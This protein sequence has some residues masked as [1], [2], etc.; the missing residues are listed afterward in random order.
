MVVSLINP[1]VNY[2]ELTKVN[3]EDKNKELDLYELELL[4]EKVIISIGSIQN[5]F[6]KHNI[7]YFPIYLI[8]K[9]NKGSQIGV[10][11][12]K[13]TNTLDCFDDKG[14]LLIESVGD[15]LLYSFINPEY[16]KELK[17]ILDNM[18]EK[19]DKIEEIEELPEKKE[20]I[21]PKNRIDIFDFIP[22]LFKKVILLKEE[23]HKT[24]KKIRR[25]YYENST[26]SWIQK[27]MK[28]PNYF[29]L[30][31]DLNKDCLFS[32]IKEVFQSIGQQTTIQKIRNKLGEK[33][34]DSLF[35]EYRDIYNTYER[36]I[37]QEKEKI[38][39]VKIEYDKIQQRLKQGVLN[40]EERIKLI[41]R[42]K[43]LYE[44]N[45]ILKQKKKVLKEI[46]EDFLF[47]KDVHS[48]TD[49]RKKVKSCNFW[50]EEWS[51]PMLE[52]LL[53]IKFIILNYNYYKENDIQNV[54][55]CNRAVEDVENNIDGF[56]PEYYILLEK[57]GKHYKIIGYKHK[58]LF[59]Y[60]ELPFDLKLMIQDKCIEK[61]ENSFRFIP[62]F[63]LISSTPQVVE[64]KGTIF[65]G[66][67]LYDKEI[68]F[69]FYENSGDIYL[70]GKGPNE[71]IP[72]RFL[73]EFASLAKEKQWRKK[74]SNFWNQTFMLDGKNWASVVH[75]IEGSKFKNSHRDFYDSFS[76]DSGSDLSKDAK[77]AWY[78]SHSK[79]GLYKGERLRDE[80]IKPDSDFNEEKRQKLLFLAQMAKFTQN[81]ELKQILLNTKNAMLLHQRKKQEPELYNSLML[82]REKIQ[83]NNI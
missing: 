58:V 83:N 21:I 60:Q 77:K 16:L 64:K 68:I 8:K 53:N 69:S 48:T 51:L 13:S 42:G 27:Y 75:F 37:S 38:Q 59:T 55:E 82:V 33:V 34:S 80:S 45:E 5:N 67:P 32:I 47:M 74:L 57:I 70:P 81:P 22:S 54:L 9:N 35:H 4:N 39:M 15:P 7:S 23:T 78:A 14:N 73:L 62:E 31:V 30:D 25:R 20:I 76:L 43:E 46:L 40:R 66:V 63:Q 12:I 44:E 36:I 71:K 50:K 52:Y 56:K 49:L 79:N 24:A 6:I 11:E 29:I 17:L 2:I 3:E 28:N 19:K 41:E 10:F 1:Q 61:K 26:H 72:E 18:P 65:S